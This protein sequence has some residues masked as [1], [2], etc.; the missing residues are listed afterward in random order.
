MPQGRATGE[1]HLTAFEARPARAEQLLVPAK[2][3]FS[4]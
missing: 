1:F 4:S 2:G 3:F